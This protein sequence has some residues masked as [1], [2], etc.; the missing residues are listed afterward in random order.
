MSDGR[1]KLS[2]GCYRANVETG[3]IDRV[4]DNSYRGFATDREK[5]IGYTCKNETE[6]YT[7]D[8]ST[9]EKMKVGDLPKGGQI[10]GHLTAAAKP[11]RITSIL[12]ST[13]R[14]TRSCS[15]IRMKTEMPRCA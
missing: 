15:P 11:V 8:L 4:T 3:E 5:N 6:V 12:P 9:M 2:G 13:G 14:E 1:K 7:V 10:T